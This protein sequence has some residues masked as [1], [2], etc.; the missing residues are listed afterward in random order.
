[1]PA[2]RLFSLDYGVKHDEALL[3]WQQQQIVVIAVTVVSEQFGC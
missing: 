1:L 3:V 2:S